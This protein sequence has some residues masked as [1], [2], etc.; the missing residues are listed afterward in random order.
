MLL[1]QPLTA[2][3]SGSCT[4]C[5]TQLYTCEFWTSEYIATSNLSLAICC[6]LIV[7]YIVLYEQARIFLVRD[8]IITALLLH[9]VVCILLLMSSF[10]ISIGYILFIAIVGAIST[11]IGTYA[12]VFN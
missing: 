9:T 2:L 3:S 1:A 6:L 7:P 5:H 12:S 11:V 8:L 4:L 10:A